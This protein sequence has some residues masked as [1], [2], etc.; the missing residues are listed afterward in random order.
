M[1]KL[2]IFSIFFA[3]SI[4]GLKAGDNRFKVLVL[5][6]RG[7]QHGSFTDAA[8]IWLKATSLREHFEL[9]E[10][11]KTDRIDAQYLSGFQLIIQLDYPPY[12]WTKEAEKAFTDYIEQGRGGWVGFHHASLLGEF[13]GFPLWPWFSNFMGGIRFKNYIAKKASAT[14]H[15]EDKKHPV[16]NGVHDSFL[17]PND[18]W[19]TFDKNPRAGV[20]VIANVDEDSYQPVSDIKMGDHPV[21]WSNTKVKARNVY[22]LFGHSDSLFASEDFKTMFTNAIKWA[23][24]W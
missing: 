12:G 16:M 23:A 17:I 18:E 1:K 22:F 7:G 11:N 3:L 10:I 24:E 15:V 19:Y 13:D 8:L 14:V 5:T 4:Q 2:I 9:V 21:I 6:E 20:H